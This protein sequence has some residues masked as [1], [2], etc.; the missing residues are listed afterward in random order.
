MGIGFDQISPLLKGS[1]RDQDAAWKVLE[2]T[3]L[4]TFGPPLAKLW[5]PEVCPKRSDFPVLVL[6]KLGE[7]VIHDEGLTAPDGDAPADY[8]AWLRVVVLNCARDILRAS[9]NAQRREVPVETHHQAP[10][11]E[12]AGPALETDESGLSSS[13]T[14]MVALKRLRKSSPLRL[15]GFYCR[16]N[17]S[18]IDRELLE[19]CATTGRN[20]P[21]TEPGLVRPVEEVLT[22]LDR[23]RAELESGAAR[24]TALRRLAWILRSKEASFD[25]W[26]QDTTRVERDKNTISRWHSHAK[27]FLSEWRE[28]WQNNLKSTSS[29]GGL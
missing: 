14:A 5:S 6:A 11:P 25:T 7:R 26:A 9:R 15:L 20:K 22:L 29:A 23:H 10:S 8:T 18:L 28:R 17:P 19:A 4:L 1:Y 21:G 3:I 12:A 2:S 27:K 24:S 16:H 13:P